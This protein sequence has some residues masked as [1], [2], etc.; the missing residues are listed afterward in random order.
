MDPDKYSRL[1]ELI[2]FYNY[3][4]LIQEREI[5]GIS[6]GIVTQFVNNKTMYY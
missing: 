2:G 5:S 4:I 1:G 6:R 3:Y